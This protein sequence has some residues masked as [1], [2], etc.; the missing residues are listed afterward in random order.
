MMRTRLLVVFVSS[1]QL[2][3]PEDLSHLPMEHRGGDLVL[4]ESNGPVAQAQRSPYGGLGAS[5]RQTQEDDIWP[6]TQ[7][8]MP[9]IQD[10]QVQCEKTSV[11]VNV[12]FDRPFYGMV[13]SKG[14]YSDPNC[15]HLASG[16]GTITASFEIF[17]NTCGMSSSGNTETYGQPNPAGSYVEN[18]IIIQYDPLV[19]EVWD[20]ARKL[21]CT[22]YDYY[23]K[24]V[25]FRPFQVDMINAVTANFLGDNLQCWMQIQV[26][27]G[28][29]S[30]EV[31]GIV[32]IGQTMTMVLGIKDDENKFD[33]LVRNCVAHDGKRAP[34]Q[35]VDE[36][37][38]V[39]RPKIMSNFQKIKNFGSSASVVSY[40]YFQAFKFPDSMNVHFQCVIQVCRYNCP[41][42]VCGDA[43]AGGGVLASYNGPNPPSVQPAANSYSNPNQ[44]QF[45]VDPRNQPRP[46]GLVIS[47]E[48]LDQYT[49]PSQPKPSPTNSS[50]LQ[51]R[52]DSGLP[53]N[54]GGQRRGGPLRAQ[55]VPVNV[56]QQAGQPRSPIFPKIPGF[57]K[58]LG[59][60]LAGKAKH[61]EGQR[62]VLKRLYKREAEEDLMSDH[63]RAEVG[64][65]PVLKRIYKREAQEMADIETASVI[66]V[67][68]PGDV[69]FTLGG[70][71]GNDTFIVSNS[72]EWDPNNICMSLTSLIG[73]L[74]MLLGVL[75]VAS[76]VASFMHCQMRKKKTKKVL[77]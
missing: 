31:S 66:Q 61:E 72:A 26:G 28:P 69:A 48:A 22:W 27:K 15:V 52:A 60:L 21:R 41:D 29:W 50:P 71:E 19:Q 74:V 6:A 20:Q 38:C 49:A 68:S 18:T 2:V 53:N 25:T 10:I 64:G 40:A 34:I 59:D 63:H 8:D 47:E 57:N 14:F 3:C 35:L 13:F 7:P 9:Q 73:G 11:R 51:N 30:S 23:E 1:I 17:L 58:R 55:P 24:S 37:G 67:L 76:M 42:P 45:N 5:K 33:M 32:K 16:S 77:N 56:R 12:K 54:G 4:K 65:R 44:R 39:T 36:L 75:V 62:P 43:A 46:S 70:S